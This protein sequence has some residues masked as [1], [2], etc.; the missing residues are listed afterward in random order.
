MTCDCHLGKHT[1]NT[2]THLLAHSATLW[3]QKNKHEMQGIMHHM[4]QVKEMHITLQLKGHF[5]QI[6]KKNVL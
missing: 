3:V 1:Q 6:K 4:I 2:Y 5:T